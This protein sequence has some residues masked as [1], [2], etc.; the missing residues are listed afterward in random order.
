MD[1]EFRWV[2][3]GQLPDWHGGLPAGGA[4]RVHRVPVSAGPSR[5]RHLAAEGLP[6]RSVPSH[7]ITGAGVTFD[8]MCPAGVTG[9]SISGISYQGSKLD[10]SFS[11]GSVTVKVRARAGPWAPPLEVELWPSQA[12][13]PLP[14]GRALPQT[15]PG[16][17]GLC[18]GLCRLPR[19]APPHRTRG[20]L[21]FL[22]WPDTKVLPV[23]SRD[24]RSAPG[25]SRE[26]LS[27]V[28]DTCQTPQDHIWATLGPSAPLPPSPWLCL[29]LCS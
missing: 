7:R 23:G 12:R 20:F 11:V 25:I 6:H 14:P 29:G 10:F 3:G 27:K 13:L 24:S 1:R 5:G 8:P 22:G 4:L 9:V 28:L 19:N 16:A 21:P 2:G 15:P 18:Q 26:S 17:Q